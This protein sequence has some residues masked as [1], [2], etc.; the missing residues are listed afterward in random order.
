MADVR[1]AV[2]KGLRIDALTRDAIAQW[3]HP[4]E[5]WR[6][7]RFRLD[8][9]DHLRRVR[10]DKTDVSRYGDLLPAGGVR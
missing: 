9:R 6:A 3:L 10:V 8:G 4:R 1:Q 7:T 5:E 2:E